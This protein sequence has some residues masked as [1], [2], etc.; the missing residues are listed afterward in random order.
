M[1]AHPGSGRQEVALLPDD[2]LAVWVPARPVEG[3][4]NAAVERAVAAALRLRPRQVH[5]VRGFSSRQ[6][7]LEIETL[8]LDQVRARLSG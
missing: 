7:L 8:T 5:V 3:Q 4:A 2:T 1:R 6:K